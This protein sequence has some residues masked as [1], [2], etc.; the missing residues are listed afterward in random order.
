[1]EIPWKSRMNLGQEAA[2][3]PLL[4]RATL[5]RAIHENPTLAALCIAGYVPFCECP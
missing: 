4:T 5:P 2:S 3:A 1:M